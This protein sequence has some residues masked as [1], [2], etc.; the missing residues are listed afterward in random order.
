RGLGEAAPGAAGEE[1]VEHSRQVFGRD[2][3]AV[4]GD[5]QDDG[6]IVLVAAQDEGDAARVNAGTGGVLDGVAGDLLQGEA[7][8]LGVAFDLPRG[9]SGGG[10]PAAGTAPAAALLR[11][12]LD[13]RVDPVDDELPPVV[14]DEV[15]DQGQQVHP[16]HLEVGGEV[17]EPDH[18]EEHLQGV[19][20]ALVL[21]TD[22]GQ[23]GGDV[24]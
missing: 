2:A 19:A 7:Q 5:V 11:R 20:Q 1:G 10:L 8:P 9:G 22:A 14:V 3:D 12:Y 16:L 15:A 21:L 18:V 24:V 13:P 6:G 23:G 4:V 17:L